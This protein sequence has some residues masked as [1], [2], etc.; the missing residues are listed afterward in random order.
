M[1]LDELRKELR[2]LLDDVAQPYLWEDTTLTAYL[3]EAEREACIRARLIYD[4][5]GTLTQLSVGAGENTAALDPLILAVDRVY[6]VV[7]GRSR[8]LMRTTVDDLDDQLGSYWKTT[9]GQPSRFYDEQTYLGV[10]PTPTVDTDLSLAVWR[11]PLEPMAD[12]DDEPDI[13]ERFHFQLLDWAAHLAF[14]RRD[15]DAQD[16]QRAAN[17]EA[18]F[19]NSFGVRPDANVQR[20]RRL[21]KVP[22]C[23]PTW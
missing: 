7:N 3:N 6:T 12:N 19:T 2:T 5:D 20:K 13:A 17:H 4:E 14:K 18:R 10:C 8:I 16:Q 11:L 9:T 21:K 22:V 15:A 1:T 23:W